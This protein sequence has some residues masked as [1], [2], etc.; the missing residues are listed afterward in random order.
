M[1][2]LT[3][4]VAACALTQPSW[5]RARGM[6]SDVARVVLIESA[7][8]DNSVR[9]P[10]ADSLVRAATVGLRVS[11]PTIANALPGALAWLRLQQ[12]TRELVVL[13]ASAGGSLDSLDI[14][15][16]PSDVRVM[17]TTRLGVDTPTPTRVVLT[18]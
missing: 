14:A 15:R 10:R 3:L 16:I 8:A 1:R 7:R 11:T 2:V 4:L 18:T 9:E 5:S 13:T 6:S 12:A 17:V